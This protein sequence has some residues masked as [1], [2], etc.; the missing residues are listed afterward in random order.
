M[1]G[2]LLGHL[3]FVAIAGLLDSDF[4]CHKVSAIPQK[5]PLQ[6]VQIDNEA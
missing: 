6:S 1:M 4:Q 5:E 3:F 2:T